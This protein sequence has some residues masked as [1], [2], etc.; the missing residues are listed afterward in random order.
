MAKIP[1]SGVR[2]SC[3]KAASAASTMPDEA[4]LLTRLRRALGAMA[5]GARFFGG[6]FFGGRV[7]RRERDFSAMIPHPGRIPP[8]HGRAEGVTPD[9]I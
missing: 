6:R 1:V 4:V 8:C 5:R 7:V 2:T 9:G 3:A